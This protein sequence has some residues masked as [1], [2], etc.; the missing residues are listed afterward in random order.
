MLPHFIPL[1]HRFLQPWIKLRKCTIQNH[2][3]HY[4]QLI[5][6]HFTNYIH[7]QYT[8]E[9]LSLQLIDLHLSLQLID[10]PQNQL[11][12]ATM[13]H[14]INIQTHY[15]RQIAWKKSKIAKQYRIAGDFLTKFG[16][17]VSGRTRCRWRPNY[18]PIRPN[19]SP[20][21]SNFAPTAAISGQR[22]R[23]QSPAWVEG[24]V[25]H[26]AS[27]RPTPGEEIASMCVVGQVGPFCHIWFISNFNQR[28]VIYLEKFLH[29][30]S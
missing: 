4:I 9:H 15:H 17:L 28:N 18:R 14:V 11:I 2:N 13:C 6:A 20:I 24:E 8:Q 3:N 10:L 23:L 21:R 7:A 30:W 22:H 29:Q 27:V 12:P 16:Y 1:P 5:Y 26:G 19:F 25:S